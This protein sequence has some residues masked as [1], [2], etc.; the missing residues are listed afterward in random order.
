M[1]GN[2]LFNAL[3]DQLY[4]DQSHHAA[5]RARVIEY[6]R[7]NKT[8]FKHF[9]DVTT[10]GGQRRNP[11]RKVTGSYNSPS[12]TPSPSP[13]EIDA[14]FEGHLLRMA[15]GGTWGDHMEVSAFG[16]AYKV[17]VKIYLHTSNY[18]LQWG[19]GTR[20]IGEG[21]PIVHIAYHVSGLD[22]LERLV[23]AC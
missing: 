23:V 20:K 4:G 8:H 19:R 16:E 22:A 2:C 5:I 7:D 12:L 11:K 15:K 17:D 1:T 9:L 13:D 10:G 14:V 18:V 21:G 3:S 6:M